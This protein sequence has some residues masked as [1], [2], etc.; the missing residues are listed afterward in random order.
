MTATNPFTTIGTDPSEIPRDHWNRPLVTPP[1]GGKPVA[2][3]RCTTFVSAMEDTYNLEQWKCRM[4][5]Q[6]LVDRPDLLLAVAAHRD[7]KKKLNKLVADAMEAATAN[8]AA[9]KGTALHSI[10]QQHDEGRELRAI[11]P[12][13]RADLQAYIGATSILEMDRD[14]IE[15]FMVHDRF[16]VGGTPDRVVTYRGKR[17][18]ADLKT[19]SVDYGMLKIAQQLA[20]YSRSVLYDH[21]TGTRTPVE[22][23][24]Q[25]QAIV[26]HLPAGSGTCE[27]LWVDIAAGW[28][29]VVLSAQVRKWRN[30]KH[31]A[32]PFPATPAPVG[33]P[34]LID[35]ATDEAVLRDLWS[36]HMADWTAEHTEMARLRLRDLTR[37]TE[38]T[39]E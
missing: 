31:L 6:G 39:T 17:Y 22:G 7:D 16:K 1:G 12:D 27:L 23:L 13:F 24:D 26:I 38:G 10:T 11:P 19:G 34:D 9:T 35:A 30:R 32:T 37:T 5:A 28:E 8:A 21:T 14:L 20:M 33:I 29:A 15:R 25:N 4:V 18:I 2:Y 3:S 36:L